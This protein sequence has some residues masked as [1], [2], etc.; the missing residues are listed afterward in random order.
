MRKTGL[1]MIMAAASM[2]LAPHNARGAAGSAGGWWQFELGGGAG[3]DVFSRDRT[4]DILFTGFLEYE[5]PVYSRVTLGFRLMPLFVYYQDEPGQETVWGGGIGLAARFYPFSAS[6]H[7]LYGEAEGH[8]LGNR[9][10][11]E[12]NSSNINFLIGAGIGYR[13]ACDWFGIVKFEHISNAGLGDQ[14]SGA[15]TVSAGIGYS[16]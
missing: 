16:F 1:I 10:Q 4:G 8:L 5:L 12:G 3:L 9:H 13:L 11:I 2:L 15:N 7:G 6:Y 14:N